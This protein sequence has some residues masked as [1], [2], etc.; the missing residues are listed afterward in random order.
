MESDN[1]TRDGKKK[2]KSQ[3]LITTIVL[4]ILVVGAVLYYQST[5]SKDEL[6]KHAEEELLS[7]GYEII[8]INVLS[9]EMAFKGKMR[10]G[11][12]T[13]LSRIGLAQVSKEKQC[14]K[15]RL[16]G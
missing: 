9:S 11:Q 10:Q 1:D 13:S 12:L 7:R 14:L 8:Q 16:N 2:K 3:N 6:R 15:T 4:F 5:K